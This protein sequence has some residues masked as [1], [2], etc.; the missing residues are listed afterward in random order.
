M[1]PKSP[2]QHRNRSKGV[3]QFIDSL[4]SDEKSEHR[5]TN[6]PLDDD[7][8]ID[9]FT[10]IFKGEL[11]TGEIYQVQIKASENLKI[12]KRGVITFPLKINKAEFY[13]EQLK[14]PLVFILCDLGNNTT[15]WHDIQIN[16]RTLDLYETAKHKNADYVN[17]EINPKFTLPN[18]IQEYTKY[19]KSAAARI[20][21]QEELS[22]LATSSLSEAI[23][24]VMQYE[25]ESLGLKGY[26]IFQGTELTQ[27]MKNKLVFSSIDQQTGKQIHF[28]ANEDYT[29][30]DA[31]QIK[32]AFAFPKDK[33]GLKKAQELQ[34]V[35]NG[36]IDFAV[37]PGKYVKDL[38]AFSGKR[39]INNS[40]DG[41]YSLR[42]GVQTHESEL[43]LKSRQ[44]DDEVRLRVLGWL[45]R[46]N[47]VKMDSSSFTEQPLVVNLNFNPVDNKISLHYELNNEEL[48]NVGDAFFYI[49][50][51]ED[52]KIDGEIFAYVN[53]I[54]RVFTK[55]NILSDKKDFEND[56]HI[57]LL[58]QLVFI[59]EKTGS[60]I[61][62]PFP[63]KITNKELESINMLYEM[64]KNG[65]ARCSYRTRIKKNNLIKIG[66]EITLYTQYESY[67]IFGVSVKLPTPHIKIIGK[68]NKITPENELLDIEVKKAELSFD[69]AKNHK[70]ANE[71][72]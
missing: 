66:R 39:T 31:I 2:S 27:E 25:G 24:E 10:Q 40:K 8:G 44:T 38:R 17:I 63:E 28:I 58:K 7:Y 5:F 55:V 62:Y 71:C 33:E 20:H 11:H 43:H 70:E 12:I 3:R 51:L 32:A 9:G 22:R 21:K 34:D 67:T 16:K 50:F 6:I 4:P 30:N 52:F 64:L 60:F 23:E 49:K 68:V 1:L 13:I 53:S 35:L 37:F 61:P 54:K 19:I 46:N 41:E 48:N 26:D 69:T 42:I 56:P 59:Q 45:S 18:T 29:L 14:Q 65:K 15:Y 47:L 72:L 36:K 57:H